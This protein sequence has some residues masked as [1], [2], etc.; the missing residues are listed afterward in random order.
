LVLHLSWNCR[1]RSWR[2]NKKQR[3]Q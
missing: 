3:Q 2:K 1:T